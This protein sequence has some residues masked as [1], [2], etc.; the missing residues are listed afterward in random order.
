MHENMNK[1]RKKIDVFKLI[2]LRQW[3]KVEI[4]ALLLKTNV[5]KNTQIPSDDDSSTVSTHNVLQHACYF[6]PPLRV[7]KCLYKVD[8]KTISEKDCEGNYPLHTACTRGCS[9]KV[10]Q[11]LFEKYPE[12][13]KK[14]NMDDRNPFLL[15]CKSYLWNNLFTPQ[16]W[17]VANTDLLKV[18]QTLSV[19]S[20]K[21]FT[22]RDCDG[23]TPA[24]YII[25]IEANSAVSNYVFELV[26]LDNQTFNMIGKD[27]EIN[28]QHLNNRNQ[29]NLKSILRCSALTA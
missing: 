16:K 3:R 1:K 10:I 26:G 23:M 4:Y 2:S 12:A 17:N 18:L 19:S 8:P 29:N 20:P 14:I 15:A 28:L 11:Y 22:S 25:E 6:H 21:V 24:D 9:P 27:I 13:A 5:S 7:I